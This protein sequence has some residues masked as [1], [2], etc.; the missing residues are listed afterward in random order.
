MNDMEFISRIHLAIFNAYMESA[1]KLEDEKEQEAHLLECFALL[2]FFDKRCKTAQTLD[3]IL[4]R[5]RKIEWRPLSDP[6]NEDCLCIGYCKSNCA[7]IKWDNSQKVW[8]KQ[9]VNSFEWL[10]IMRIDGMWWMPDPNLR[11]NHEQVDKRS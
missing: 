7:M 5:N 3:E 6:P 1:D 10:P 9:G 2:R 11:R 8:K 4:S